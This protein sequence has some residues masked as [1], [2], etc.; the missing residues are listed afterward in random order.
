M[1]SVRTIQL[2]LI[3]GQAVTDERT[4]L[5]KIYWLN[6]W[7]ALKP[8]TASDCYQIATIARIGIK[9]FIMCFHLVYSSSSSNR[10]PHSGSGSSR[11]PRPITPT[12]LLPTCPRCSIPPHTCL[13]VHLPLRSAWHTMS[14]AWSYDVILQL[15]SSFPLDLD[16]WK[17]Y[18]TYT[19][20]TSLC[21][22]SE[23]QWTI[24]WFIY[25]QKR[26]EAV[27]H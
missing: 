19:F 6:C 13:Q 17:F 15:H 26:C 14:A 27:P 3:H 24:F 25:F 18:F 9:H 7:A 10:S 23:Y 2:M 1:I 20:S 12:G 22:M 5:P 4:C 16:S 21:G 8:Q 11:A